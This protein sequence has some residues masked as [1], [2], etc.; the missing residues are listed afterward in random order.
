MALTDHVA[1]FARGALAAAVPNKKKPGAPVQFYSELAFPPSAFPDINAMLQQCA[2]ERG[3][4]IQPHMKMGVVPNGQKAKPLPGIPADWLV[5]RASSQFPPELYDAT[6][7]II[8][9]AAAG[10]EN[11]IRG[12]FFSGKRVRAQVSPWFWPQEGGGFSWNLHAVM[13]AGEGGERIVGLGGGADPSAFQKHAKAAPSMAT[14]ATVPG[15][16]MSTAAAFTAAAN[17]FAQAPAVAAA[18]PF[19]QAQA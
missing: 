5:L 13:D 10:V 2:Q 17:P 9:R 8:D 3:V 6:A 19:A 7:T 11:A 1:I 12:A 16:P 18:N 4:A 15:Q 14:A